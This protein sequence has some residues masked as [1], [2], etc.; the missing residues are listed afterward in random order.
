VV[1]KLAIGRFFL[2]EGSA[3]ARLVCRV[4]CSSGGANVRRRRRLFS[5]AIR[6]AVP[7]QLACGWGQTVPGR[8]MCAY[9]DRG[10]EAWR[11]TT[12]TRRT[13]GAGMNP[14]DGTYLNE[15]RRHEGVH[16]RLSSAD[17]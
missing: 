12:R 8:V 4:L 7:G 13:A 9:Y 3:V 14:A 17:V 6:N 5:R 11:I 2:E 15:F 1:A 16:Q 10:G